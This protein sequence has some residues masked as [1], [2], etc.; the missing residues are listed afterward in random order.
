MTDLTAE[1]LPKLKAHRIPGLDLGSN[2]VYPNYE[3]QSILNIPGSISHFLGAPSFGAPPFHEDILS[4]LG[5]PYQRVVLL[6]VD[7][8]AMQRLQ[9]WINEP[10]FAVWKRLAATGMLAPLTSVSPSTTC[11]ALTS[12]WTGRSPGE[13]GIVGYELFLKE[14]GLVANIIQHS[15]FALRGPAGALSRLVLIP[16]SS[17]V[18]QPWVPTWRLPG[19]RRMLSSM[20]GFWAQAFQRCSSRMSRPTASCPPPTFGSVSANNSQLIRMSELTSGCTGPT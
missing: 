9:V 17:W 12:V 2:F 16:W 20:A 8:L 15:P 6:L 4:R 5:G 3:G 7:A 14:Y 10:E 19:S 13:H 1:L 11:A 18:N